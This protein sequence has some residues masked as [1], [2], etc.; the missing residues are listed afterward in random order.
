MLTFDD[1]WLLNRDV[2]WILVVDGKNPTAVTTPNVGVGQRHFS[3]PRHL[4]SGTMIM[5]KFLF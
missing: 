4:Q 3:V 1:T 5:L 2:D